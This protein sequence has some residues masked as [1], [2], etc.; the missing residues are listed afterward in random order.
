MGLLDK[1]RE[2]FGSGLGGTERPT[3]P[4]DQRR[5]QDPALAAWQ[6]QAP[7]RKRGPRAVR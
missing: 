4:P 3:V 7:A 1:F 5:A 2:T 6:E